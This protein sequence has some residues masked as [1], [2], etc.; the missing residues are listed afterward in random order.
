M[1]S[2]QKEKL[3]TTGIIKDHFYLQNNDAKMQ[4]YVEGNISSNKIL[5]MVHGGPG[6]G[7]LYFNT[8]EATHIAEQKMAVAYWDQ[9][10]AGS[11]QGNHSD[12]DI[13]SYADDLKKLILLLH[14]RYGPSKKIYLLAH[15]WGGL[16]A[17]YFLEKE[18]NQSLIAGWIQV[19]GVHNYALTDSLSRQELIRVGLE[20]IAANKHVEDWKEMVDYCKTHD[21][22]NNYK[23]ARKI[24]VYANQTDDLL[25]EVYKGTSQKELVNYFIREY[26]YPIT[27]FPVN[28][29]YNVILEKIEK[30]AY[31][32][33]IS[34][35]LPK[36]TIPTFL[37]WGKYDYVAP[38]GLKD[39]ILENIGSTDKSV[40]IFEHSGHTPMFQQP[41]LFWQTVTGWIELH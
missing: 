32:L 31:E 14:H 2:C 26:Q 20:Q 30:Q 40:E 15:S 8:K 21:P 29:I 4:V 41:E 27:T 12:T 13:E 35:S 16:I 28:K 5:I 23:V 3:S 17:P 24:N 11:S 9:R 22:T 34:G 36:I 7:S 38:L 19:D 6:D 39:N 33:N 10:L 18:D 1:Q 37:L 25:S